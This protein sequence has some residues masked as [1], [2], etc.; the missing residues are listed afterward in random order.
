MIRFLELELTSRCNAKCSVCPRYDSGNL[1]K[2]FQIHDLSL[3]ALQNNISTEIWN[4]IETVVL[5]G[6]VG[7]AGFHPRL[8]EILNF[9]KDKN[10]SLHTNGSNRSVEWWKSIVRDNLITRFCLDGID[11]E[12]HFVY[13]QTSFDKVLEHAKAYISAGGRA[14]WLFII[15]KHNQHQV[16]AAKQ[17]ASDLGF[18]SFVAIYS[19]RYDIDERTQSPENFNL[20]LSHI[21]NSKRNGFTW[22][23]TNVKIENFYGT[24]QKK[25]LE[26]PNLKSKLIYIAA[27]GNVWPCCYYG[28]S[29]LTKN[30]IFWKVYKNK[31]LNNNETTVNINTRPLVEI[32]QDKGWQW[33]DSYVTINNPKT[34]Q[35]YC[36]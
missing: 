3:E 20:N 26:C 15:F 8:T 35:Q 27:D 14:E 28:S 18:E 10:T 29:N 22:P 16:E 5:K 31:A 4:N 36:G 34:C 1:N 21:I 30:N 13:R 25:V 19:D 11:A 7:D 32:L 2:N 17:M 9:L 6:T 33:W 24:N 12:T 23:S